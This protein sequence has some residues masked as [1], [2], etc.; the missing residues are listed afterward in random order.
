MVPRLSAILRLMFGRRYSFQVEITRTLL[1]EV[2]LP[3]SS[4]STFSMEGNSYRRAFVLVR[5]NSFPYEL[6]HFGKQTL[7]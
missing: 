1:G 7:G 6:S 5:A 2:N 3:F 4:F